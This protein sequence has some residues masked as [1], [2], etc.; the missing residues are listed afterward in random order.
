MSSKQRTS[1]QDWIQD[2]FSPL[3]CVLASSEAEETAARNNLTFTELLHPFAKLRT[4]VTLKDADGSNHNVPQLNILLQDFNEGRRPLNQ[5]LI[6]EKVD[7]ENCG[8]EEMVT[9]Y[10][11]K[12]SLDAPGYTPWFDV[13]TKLYIQGLPVMENEYLKHQL[14]CIFVTTTRCTDPVDQFRGMIQ[15]HQRNV[16]KKPGPTVPHFNGTEAV[17]YFILVHDL[18]GE[19]TEQNGRAMFDRVKQ[20]FMSD[21]CYYLPLNSKQADNDTSISDLWLNFNNRF[22]TIETRNTATEPDFPVPNQPIQDPTSSLDHPLADVDTSSVPSPKSIKLSKA[23][24]SNIASCLGSEDIARLTDM[25]RDF[26]LKGLLPFVEKQIRVLHDGVANRKTRS[27]FSGAKRWFGNKPNSGT[28]TSVV[29]AKD[30]TELQVRKLADLYFLMKMYKQ[31]YSYYHT[32]KKDF[33]MDEAWTL[34]A[35][36]AELTALS[37][38]M[39]SL[40]DS[41]KRYRSDYME[42]A[43]TKYLTVCQTPEFAIRATL[44]DG[45]CLKQQSMFLEAA[46]SYTRMTNELSDLRSAMLLEQAAYCFLL[47]A[48]PHIRKYGF[49]IV[50]S[51]YRFAK[52]GSC[53]RHAARLYGQGAQVYDGKG[54][55]MS[56]Q[57]ILYSLGHQKFMLK[58]YSAAAEFF[59]NLMTVSTAGENHLQQMVQ[60]REYFLVQHARFKEDPTVAVV[61]V[62]K[63]GAQDISVSLAKCHQPC[64]KHWQAIEQ[65]IQEGVTGKETLVM[66]ATSQVLFSNSTTN[67]LSPQGVVGE[68]IYVTVPVSNDFN[69]SLRL[70]RAHLLWKFT[71]E[72]GGETFSNDKQDNKSPPYVKV[73]AVDTVT[74]ESGGTEQVVLEISVSLPGKLNIIG[75]EYSI[76]ALF[77]DR[78]PTDHEIR[79]KQY[80]QISGPRINTIKDHKTR[81]V[82][83]TDNRFSIQI[84]QTQP[85]LQA[86]LKTPDTLLSSELRC[87]EL[88]LKNSSSLK[89]TNLHLVSTAPGRF[90]FSRS[91]NNS[92]FEYPAVRENNQFPLRQEREDGS[93]SQV[94]LDILPVPVSKESGGGCGELEPGASLKIPVWLR[95]QTS[96]EAVEESA[97]LYYENAIKDGSKPPYRLLELKLRVKI[98]QA[99]VVTASW[100]EDEEGRDPPSLQVTAHN[101]MKENSKPI[102]VSQMCLLSERSELSSLECPASSAVIGPAEKVSFSV[103]TK[104]TK[105]NSDPIKPLHF[106]SLASAKHKGHALHGPPFVDFLKPLFIYSGKRAV[107]PVLRDEAVILIWRGEGAQPILGE[108]VVPLPTAG[109]QHLL[110]PY[111]LIPHYTHQLT[112]DFKAVPF[113]TLDI[114]L[115][116]ASNTFH[117]AIIKNPRRAASKKDLLQLKVKGAEK[118]VRWA[119]STDVRTVLE[120]NDLPTINLGITVCRPGIYHVNNLHYALS[121]S[122]EEERSNLDYSWTSIGVHFNVVQG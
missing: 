67:Q 31:S 65:S 61:A 73:S 75:L 44:F 43:V 33:Q 47:T 10:Y 66:N 62:P 93:I 64:H 117:Q 22:S 55:G 7:N 3:I 8:K 49:H 13:W 114:R 102:T 90:S 35:A 38:F 82:Y 103:R 54:W 20:S 50:L 72:D 119:G 23:D 109:D 107:P 80:F 121:E 42:D 27:L 56:S 29:Y 1:A 45:L 69:T 51:G 98:R 52:T 70:R 4:D 46:K 24:S 21:S 26:V 2:Y 100:K 41:G 110:H 30:A 79:G 95:I 77:L 94:S 19:V 16:N 86:E 113:A 60:L 48:S 63:I 89:L 104:P 40:A 58:D 39:L 9:K 32:A 53:K 122:V 34:Y 11:D 28:G 76:K 74:I 81:I 115:E 17:Q 116:V 25:M 59:N 101:T 111:Q 12:I 99:V 87:I 91:R 106:S 36:A 5:K 96:E 92:V 118:G 83:G 105:E 85:L 120:E 112:H 71:S 6:L 78:E 108:T 18:Q 84:R 97:F 57:H 14:G 37:S 15:L 68:S 88:E